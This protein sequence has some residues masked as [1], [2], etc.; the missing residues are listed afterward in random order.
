MKL[1][2]KQDEIVHG[3]FA[4]EIVV[5]AKLKE[6]KRTGVGFVDDMYGGRGM[7]PSTVTLLT[8]TPGAGKTTLALELAESLTDQGH[9]CLFNTCEESVYQAKATVE[10][11]GLTGN[12]YIGQDSLIDATWKEMVAKN[13]RDEPS[14]LEHARLIMAKH[15]DQQFFLICDSL[16]TL[17]DGKYHDYAINQKTNVRVLGRI[18]EFCKSQYSIAIMIGQ[19]GKDGKFSGENKLKHMVD[20]HAHLFYDED[21]DSDDYGTRY[22]SMNK[23]R[24]GYSGRTYALRIGE[25]GLRPKGAAGGLMKAA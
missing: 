23:N 24:F 5:P 10:R 11:L 17:D 18:T 7:T 19:V 25:K 15:P 13:R 4:H 14:V 21:P 9:V 3:T 16:Q 22:F 8:G 2:I 20:C 6:R 1:N 12:F